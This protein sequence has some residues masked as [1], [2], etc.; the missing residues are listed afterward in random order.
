MTGP[1]VTT[2]SFSH[3]DIVHNSAKI[4]NGLLEGAA[5]RV[6]YL[7]IFFFPRR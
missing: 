4:M 7:H 6:L 1:N 5:E 3:P 2:V